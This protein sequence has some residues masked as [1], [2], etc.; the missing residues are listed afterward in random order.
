MPHLINLAVS[1]NIV[2][3]GKV[4]YP[5]PSIPDLDCHL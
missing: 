4:G 5:L 1:F 2:Q 3:I